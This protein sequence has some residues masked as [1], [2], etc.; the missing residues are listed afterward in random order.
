MLKLSDR[1]INRG[2][3]VLI[4][5]WPA[6]QDLPLSFPQKNDNP[7]FIIFGFIRIF[8]NRDIQT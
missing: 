6:F 7:H 4:V 3:R 2:R 8:Q 1:I 5:I